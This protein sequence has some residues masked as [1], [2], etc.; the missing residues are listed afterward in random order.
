MQFASREEWL[1]F[2]E[3]EAARLR[4][5]FRPW[6][7]RVRDRK[8][9][10]WGIAAL[11]RHDNVLYCGASFCAFADRPRF[12]RHEAVYRAL[13]LGRV[14]PEFQWTDDCAVPRYMRP[15]DVVQP[16]F[17]RLK[18]YLQ[19]PRS[20]RTTVREMLIAHALQQEHK[21]AVES[22]SKPV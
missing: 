20:C 17:T 15:S 19:I 21:A 4:E 8:G 10:P 5:A 18:F 7:K 2:C 9:R 3:R 11:W 1:L 13:S 16:A 14:V 6:I 22:A 12:D